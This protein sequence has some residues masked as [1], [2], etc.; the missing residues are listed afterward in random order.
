M[1]KLT[2]FCLQTL[3][4]LV[5]SI[6]FSIHT[7]YCAEPK[8]YTPNEIIIM[9]QSGDEKQQE[10]AINGISDKM[11]RVKSA[12]KTAGIK[13]ALYDLLTKTAEPTK[14]F[15]DLMFYP[16]PIKIMMV[17][18]DFKETRALPYMLNNTGKRYVIISLAV[19]GEPA[20]E[21][22]LRKLQSGDKKGE[23][24]Q[25][26]EIL[27]STKTPNLVRGNRIMPN[28]YAST[29]TPQGLVREKIIKALKQSLNDPD[30][31]IRHGT[32]S[33]L[34]IVN[35]PLDKALLDE[36][37]KKDPHRMTPEKKA[38]HEQ[39]FKEKHEKWRIEKEERARKGLPDPEQEKFENYK[40]D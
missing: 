16:I 18:G 29:Y 34:R 40:G 17:M 2:G 4:A 6:L 27:L 9:L 26:F 25:F 21:P 15:E 5:A 23:A 39:V 30:S 3:L 38:K 28:P 31:G 36:A 37:D 10:N 11:G 12:Y 13:N 19:M 33:V 14:S 35:N 22:M 32:I 8:E 1:R 24:L 7:G 20:V